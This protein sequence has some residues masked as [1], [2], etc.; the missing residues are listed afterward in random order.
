MTTLHFVLRHAH[1]SM[2]MLALVSGAAGRVTQLM[3]VPMLVFE[4]ALALWLIIKGVAAPAT[5]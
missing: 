1:L 2:G 4:V 5:R 3:W